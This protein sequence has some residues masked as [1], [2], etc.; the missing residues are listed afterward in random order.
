MLLCKRI[1]LTNP[2][3]FIRQ[4][5]LWHLRDPNESRNCSEKQA[6]GLGDFR[7]RGCCVAVCF[8]FLSAPVLRSITGGIVT[9]CIP[10]DAGKSLRCAIFDDWDFKEQTWPY[11]LRYWTSMSSSA[12]PDNVSYCIDTA[13]SSRDSGVYPVCEWYPELSHSRHCREPFSFKGPHQGL[14]CASV[15]LWTYL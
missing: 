8:Y 5:N 3:W 7:L 4:L 10:F 14:H 9:T 11:W 6:R 1:T 13:V 2:V 15:C 12:R